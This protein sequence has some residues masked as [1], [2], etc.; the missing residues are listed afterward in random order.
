MKIVDTMKAVKIDILAP[1]TQ[2]IHEAM[3]VN[4]VLRIPFTVGSLGKKYV[5]KPAFPPYPRWVPGSKDGVARLRAALRPHERGV[6]FRDS[7]NSSA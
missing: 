7:L 5:N 6:G 3:N 4:A 1:M 2:P